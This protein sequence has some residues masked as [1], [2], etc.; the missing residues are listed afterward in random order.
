MRK[1]TEVMSGG[2]VFVLDYWR[3][4]I[5][6]ATAA[7]GVYLTATSFY[8]SY[9]MSTSTTSMQVTSS[10]YSNTASIID[11]ID[12]ALAGTNYSNKTVIS[13]EARNNALNLEN[14]PYKSGTPV[15]GYKTTKATQFVR[16]YRECVNS[17]QGGR[18]R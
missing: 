4:V 5:D 8:Y 12:D 14:P 9:L 17:P 11:D 1:N 16:V 15:V 6:T 7:Y 3:G 18:V 13:A 2:D 10:Q